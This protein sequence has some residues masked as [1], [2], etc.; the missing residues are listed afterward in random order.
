M[1]KVLSNGL[2]CMK[3]ILADK[4]ASVSETSFLVVLFEEGTTNTPSSTASGPTSKGPSIL[5]QDYPSEKRIKF[6]E[7]SDDKT[8][9]FP[10]VFV[11]PFWH[12]H[13]PFGGG[14]LGWDIVHLINEGENTSYVIYFFTF[15][16]ALANEKATVIRFT[17]VLAFRRSRETRSSEL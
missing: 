17:T 2:A 4:K 1:V 16:Y 6:V 12:V 7:G 13:L 9:L 10:P 3:G 5:T 8:P 11:P 14:G 15:S